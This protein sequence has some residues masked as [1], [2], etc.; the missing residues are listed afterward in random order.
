MGKRLRAEPIVA[1]TAQGRV[2]FYGYLPQ[3]ED[4]CV[5]WNPEVTKDS[6]DRLDA[7]VFGVTALLVQPPKGYSAGGASG[8]IARSAS[9][10]RLPSMRG[11]STLGMSSRS[12]MRP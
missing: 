4:Q 10:A 11:T 6:P 5:T 8:L 1:A 7:M 9:Y 2:K 12:R 3:L